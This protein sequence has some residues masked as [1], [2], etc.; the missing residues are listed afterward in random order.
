MML[1]RPP[2]PRINRHSPLAKG[3][4]FAGL[5]GGASTL[6]MVDSSGYGNHGTLTNMDP[7]TDWVFDSTL[8]R[9]VVDYISA[10]NQYVGGSLVISGFYAITFSVWF[11]T[12]TS[13]SAYLLSFPEASAA[14][15]S[16]LSIGTSTVVA[17]VRTD[18]SAASEVAYSTTPHNGIW[19]NLC[20]QWYDNKTRIYFDGQ[21][22]NQATVV[23]TTTD[24][25][26]GKFSIG[27]FNGFGYDAGR[28]TGLLSD[29]MVWNRVLSP[30]EIKQLADPSN[31]MLSG[32]ILP[33]RRRLWA[34]SAGTAF[35]P[36]WARHCNNLIGAA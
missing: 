31:V 4:V 29:E 9:W 25:S 5:G 14:V 27:Q 33:P 35:K 36:W 28:Y 1:Q 16:A 13:Q 6:Q 20:G 21:Y 26:Y 17:A 32:L 30:S 8:G 23:G 22:R 2:F 18:A 11:K 34:V 3:L 12:S 19:H 7:P 10:V 24:A 15:G